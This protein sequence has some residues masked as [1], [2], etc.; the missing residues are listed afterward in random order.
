MRFAR[1]GWKGRLL[2]RLAGHSIPL[3]GELVL[4]RAVHANRRRRTCQQRRCCQPDVLFGAVTAS[5]EETG[6]TDAE[7]LC[8][9]ERHSQHSP[10]RGTNCSPRAIGAH[11]T[12]HS[13][14]ADDGKARNLTAG[15]RRATPERS[16]PLCT[17]ARANQFG[18]SPAQ[19]MISLRRGPRRRGRTPDN[20]RS[21]FPWEA[22]RIGGGTW[23][24]AP[25]LRRRSPDRPGCC[26]PT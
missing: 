12:S 4:S 15:G 17:T 16:E 21:S 9:A 8:G 26:P 10:S 13:R 6:A 22:A 7:G 20:H 24:T 19:T 2:E 14:V 1:S 23:P 3:L 5:R 18:A 11:E 25:V